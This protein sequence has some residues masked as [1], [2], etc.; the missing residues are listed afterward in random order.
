MRQ[1]ENQKYVLDKKGPPISILP[2]FV[3]SNRFQIEIQVKTRKKPGVNQKFSLIEIL[4]FEKFQF[5]LRE[6]SNSLFDLEFATEKRYNGT[7]LDKMNK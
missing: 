6:F 2:Y 3:S 4:F 7:F 1:W 5:D